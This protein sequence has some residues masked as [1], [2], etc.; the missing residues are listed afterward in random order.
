MPIREEIRCAIEP[1]VDLPARTW[2]PAVD[3]H[4]HL[5]HRILSANLSRLK[6]A[7]KMNFQSQNNKLFVLSKYYG[8]I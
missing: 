4:P 6:W 2:D 5:R 7:K 3:L 8:K 1:E